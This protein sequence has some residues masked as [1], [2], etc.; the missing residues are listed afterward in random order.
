MMLR[1]ERLTTSSRVQILQLHVVTSSVSAASLVDGAYLP[2]VTGGFLNVS[3]SEGSAS[4]VTADGASNATVIGADLK[5]CKGYVHVIDNILLTDELKAGLGPLGSGNTTVPGETTVPGGNTTVTVPGNTTVVNPGNTTLPPAV[6]PTGPDLNVTRGEDGK[7]TV[8]SG[9]WAPQK[10]QGPEP[11]GIR[12]RSTGVVNIG[13]QYAGDNGYFSID[14]ADGLDDPCF[15]ASLAAMFGQ[16]L[17]QFK[18]VEG[19]VECLAEADGS[20]CICLAP[21]GKPAVK[22]N[23]RKWDGNIDFNRF[24]KI[25]RSRANLEDSSSAATLSENKA[26]TELGLQDIL[27]IV[28]CAA[29]VA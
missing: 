25:L 1:Q 24:L 18:D 7:Y 13:T 16:T 20:N 8:C 3:L 28:N 22:E 4:F 6:P 5:S 19:G 17:C 9:R 10:F 2:T 14:A 23:N 26:K 27:N 15:K 11:C 12:V 29:E 21:L